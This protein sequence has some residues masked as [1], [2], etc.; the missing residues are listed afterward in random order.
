MQALTFGYLSAADLAPLEVIR[1]AARAG[2]ASVGVRIS[3]RK[4]G[5]GFLP[6]VIGDA[7]A[8]NA[9]RTCLGDSGM[10]LSS[11]STYHLYPDIGLNDLIPVIET[12]AAL[13]AEYI[14]AASYE[15]DQSRMADLMRKY[16][17]RAAESGIKIAF[18]TVSYSAAPTL[19]SACALMDA[20][21]EPNFG[22]LLDPLHIARG[23]STFAKIAQ[24][25]PQKIFFAQLCDASA[26]KPDGVDLATEAKSMRL[27]PGEGALPLREFLSFLPAGLEIEAELP[28]WADRH[29]SGGERAK[30]AH[31]KS[32]AYLS[33]GANKNM[34]AR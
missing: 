15:P 6:D 20:V 8:T 32:A 2:F 16:S 18:E 34:V 28:I 1:A 10:R 25:D 17:R 9:I 5:D 31:Q 30:I 22:L 7:T 19:E 11:I 3:G 27:Y 24:I 12:A 21:N 14:V 33:Q 29:L 4:P 23:G 13:G 26:A